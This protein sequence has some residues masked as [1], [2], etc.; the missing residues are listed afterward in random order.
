MTN[1]FVKQP[2]AGR[3]AALVGIFML[4]LALRAAALV[5]APLLP[6]AGPALGFNSASTGLLAMLAPGTFAVFGFFAPA[7][8]KRLGL[9]R[10]LAVSI[11]LA[12]VGQVL[13]VFMPNVWS[14]LA[15]SIVAL[16]GYG[17][18]NVVLPPLIK[19][20]YPDRLA[21]VTAIYVTL[22]SIGTAVSPLFA[23]PI[24]QATNWQF[25]MAIWA[26]LSLVV[27]VP[28]AIQ[29]AQDRRVERLTGKKR[30][31]D[32]FATSATPAKIN[33]FR[34]PVAWGLAIF[35]AGNSAQTYV[36]FTWIPLYLV[37][38]GFTP[39]EAGTALAYFAILALPV[40]LLVPLWLP[41]LKKPFYAI[42]LFT[43]LWIVGHA[44][45]YFSPENGTWLW[46]TFSGLG[47]ATFATALLM[48]NLRSR[49]TRGASVL[50]GFSQG[51]G[52]AGAC[53][54]PF[55]FGIIRDATGGW[56]ASFATLGVCVVVM[57][58]GATMISPKRYIED[59]S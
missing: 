35:L 39:G 44:G 9:E 32:P 10:A 45:M 58:V 27:A 51:L 53:A 52:Y 6:E 38:H 22:I 49:T 17:I 30:P 2:L 21:L 43:V 55:L 11:T 42:L 29:L 14:Y 41:K 54:A 7:L 59:V 15:L 46:I 13:R 57:L 23:V 28:W 18:G 31:D 1:L 5:V 24:A 19:K 8:I 47:Q 36:Y 37:E 48:I 56:G 4:A 20:Y 12:V 33:P 3:I 34:S 16:A 40:S 50:G 25:S 26:L